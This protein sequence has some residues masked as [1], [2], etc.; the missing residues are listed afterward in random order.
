[1]APLGQFVGEIPRAFGRPQKHALR[2]AAR[3]V[4]D[5]ATQHIQQFGVAVLASRPARA[6]LAN[7]SRR[8]R[9]LIELTQSLAHRVLRQLARPRRRRDPS[10]PE[11]PRLRRGERAPLTLVELRC[12]QAVA[13]RDRYLGITHASLVL[14]PNQQILH[15]I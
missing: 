4:L 12:H 7:P 6:R 11:R 1:M 10:V 13:L 8:Q 5:E 2:I 3:L 9:L 15:L 14:P